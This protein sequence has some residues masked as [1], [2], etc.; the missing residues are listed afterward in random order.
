MAELET[1]ALERDELEAL[2]LADLEG[3]YQDAAAAAMGV[4]RQTFGRIIESARRKV[5]DALLNA[6]A[7]QIAT[8]GAAVR[9]RPCRRSAAQ[10][11]RN[12][13]RRPTMKLAITAEGGGLDARPDSRFGRCS[14]FVLVDPATMQ[15][16][17]IVNDAAGS[18]SGAG[19]GAAQAL[20]RA[21]AGA[22]LTGH[23]GP[24]AFAVLSQAGIAVYQ[25]S[26]P[27]VAAAV[28]QFKSG[29]LRPLT[30]PDSAGHAGTRG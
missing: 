17:T 7:L 26:A 12:T 20:V 18:D 24:K 29:N 16:E 3:R 2:R 19:I 22:V 23:C 13:E 11:A 15:F 10:S 14:R 8:D 9:P 5:A 25:V 1:V 28:E 30:G 27:T 6:R 4:S 21:G